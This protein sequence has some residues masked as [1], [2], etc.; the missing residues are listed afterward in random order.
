MAL[1]YHNSSQAS[2]SRVA[3]PIPTPQMSPPLTTGLQD[4]PQQPCLNIHNLRAIA[5]NIKDTLSAAIAELRLDIHTL[6]DRVLQVE[7]TTAKH[8][9]VLRKVT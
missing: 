4:N 1:S 7:K 5:A 6:N 8:D 2:D 3:G 9:T